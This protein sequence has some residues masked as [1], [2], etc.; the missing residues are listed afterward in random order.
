M[1]KLFLGS[2]ALVALSLGTLAA[3]AAER[4]VPAYTPP[5][6]PAPVYT[7]TGCY[8]GANAG[9][10]GGTS[11]VSTVAGSVVTNGP[12]LPPS[13][14]AAPPGTQIADS[15]NLTGSIGGFQAG[16]N[17]QFGA[18]FWGVEVDGAPTNKGGQASGSGLPPSPP[19]GQTLSFRPRGLWLLPPRASSA[20]PGGI[21]RFC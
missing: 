7:W 15:F 12:L 14:L 2:V 16:G 21:G 5:P 10:S 13:P 17:F 3:F 11:T 1:K 19:A 18:W 9:T 6:P 4:P 20:G 8:I